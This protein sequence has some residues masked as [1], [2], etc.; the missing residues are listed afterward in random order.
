MFPKS[1]QELIEY[2][3]SF[4]G[5]GPRQATRFVLFLLKRKDLVVSIR[6]SLKSLKDD[7]TLCQQCF[8]PYEK[9]EGENCSICLDPKRNSKLICVVEKENDALRIERTKIYNG[10]YYVLGGTLTPL[11]QD[12][13]I[14]ARVQ[15]FKKRLANDASIKDVELILAL[16]P[17]REGAF[18]EAYLQETL[19]KIE[20]YPR[21]R[22]TRLGRGLSTGSEL[23]YVDEE[24]LRSALDG[25]Q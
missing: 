25:R 20:G 2:F 5:V 6:D 3:S 21:L 15:N 18:T 19:K 24:T 4:P 16:N 23:E 11:R 10:I 13:Q 12:A 7:V 1:I 22:I 17:T 9:G 14:K 8:F